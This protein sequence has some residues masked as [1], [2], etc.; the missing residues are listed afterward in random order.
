[1]SINFECNTAEAESYICILPFDLFVL[2]SFAACVI[3]RILR[4][5]T[6]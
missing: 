5:L 6:T 2:R 1:M 4:V 3:A